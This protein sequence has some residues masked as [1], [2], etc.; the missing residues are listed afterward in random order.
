MVEQTNAANILPFV[1]HSITWLIL[2]VRRKFMKTL[3]F[4]LL[5][6]S[7]LITTGCTRSGDQPFTYIASRDGTF[8]LTVQSTGQKVGIKTEDYELTVNGVPYGRIDDGDAIFVKKSKVYRNDVKILPTAKT[9][10][11]VDQT[12]EQGGGGQPATR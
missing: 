7:L 10:R 1:P 5:L 4:Q 12:A 8:S 2:N 11:S 6:V 3:T 9:D